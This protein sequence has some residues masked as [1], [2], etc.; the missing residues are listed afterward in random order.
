M[1][2]DKIDNGT[3]ISVIANKL[4]VFFKLKNEIRNGYFD[5]C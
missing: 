3:I 4:D 2:V 5:N 1:K